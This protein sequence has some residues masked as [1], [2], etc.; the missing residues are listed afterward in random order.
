MDVT[1]DVDVKLCNRRP[2]VLTSY[3]FLDKVDFFSLFTDILTLDFLFLSATF[4]KFLC[5]IDFD[6]LLL[7]ISSARLV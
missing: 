6:R 2:S 4:G 1:L 7:L 5:S 3:T